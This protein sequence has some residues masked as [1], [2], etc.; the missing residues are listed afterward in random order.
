MSDWLGVEDDYDAKKSGR[1]IGSWDNFE[2]DDDGWKGGATSSDGASAED[3]LSAVASMGDDELLGHDIWFV[4]T[5]ASDC[6][7]AG[8]RRFWP[9]I[10]TS[11][12]VC[13]SSTSS[14]S[15]PAGFRW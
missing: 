5:G 8:M 1:G 9:R 11:S 7:G 14:L 10:V 6:D 3:M 13:S 2:D 15:V 4:A 12:A